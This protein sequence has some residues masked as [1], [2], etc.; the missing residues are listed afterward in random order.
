[1]E[2]IP[3]P[4]APYYSGQ[5]NRNGQ[6]SASSV[7]SHQIVVLSMSAGWCPKVRNMSAFYFY[8]GSIQTFSVLL[9]KSCYQ[10]FRNIAQRSSTNY[11]SDLFLLTLLPPYF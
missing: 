6:L 1:M 9:Q 8:S 3:F 11:N 10:L 4:Y 7:L 2:G 5:V